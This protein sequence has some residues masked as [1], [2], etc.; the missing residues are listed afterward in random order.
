MMDL[1]QWYCRMLCDAFLVPVGGCDGEERSIDD[2]TGRNAVTGER[3]W[4]AEPLYRMD[5]I[6]T[7]PPGRLRKLLI[8]Q[9]AQV[10]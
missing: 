6:N 5:H 7:R 3:R 9:A 2:G 4:V 10:A 1:C 8:R